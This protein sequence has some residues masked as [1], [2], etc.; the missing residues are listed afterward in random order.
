MSDF[1]LSADDLHKSYGE[2]AAVQGISF[3]IQR[4][5]VF[6]LLGPNG[7]GRQVRQALQPGREGAQRDKGAA[8]HAEDQHQR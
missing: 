7:V 3:G 8:E 6:S 1:I 4:G 5:E 2:R